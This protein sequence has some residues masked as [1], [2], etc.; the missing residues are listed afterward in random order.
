MRLHAAGSLTQ[1]FPFARQKLL[2]M[3]SNHQWPGW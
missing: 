1:T 2:E 3:L